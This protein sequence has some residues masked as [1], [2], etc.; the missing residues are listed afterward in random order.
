MCD[1]CKLICYSFCLYCDT[2]LCS[3]CLKKTSEKVSGIRKC[4]RFPQTVLGLRKQ[5]NRIPQT[6]I[7]IFLAFGLVMAER[8]R[9]LFSTELAFEQLKAR[10][11]ILI[12]QRGIGLTIVSGIHEQVFTN[13][14]KI[15]YLFVIKN[16][17]YFALTMFEFYCF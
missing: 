16:N 10:A 8:F 1:E 11:G 17:I 2:L 9:F 15:I 14:F 12:S 3:K 5:K 7:G 13:T 4:K 6:K